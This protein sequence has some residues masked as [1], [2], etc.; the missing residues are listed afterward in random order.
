MPIGQLGTPNLNVSTII[1]NLYQ[2]LNSI[3]PLELAGQ[4][5]SL[6][7]G[8]TWALGMLAGAGLSGTVFGCPTNAIS[9]NFLYPNSTTTGGPLGPSLD[10]NK[11]SG[12]NVYNKVYFPKA[13]TTQQC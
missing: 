1:C 12:N 9:S 5:E 13:P 11:R 10:E 7:A 8:I 2:G 6:Q 4:S 3:T